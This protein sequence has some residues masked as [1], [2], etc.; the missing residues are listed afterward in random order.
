[1][2]TAKIINYIR[3]LMDRAE[4]IKVILEDPKSVDTI[5]EIMHKVRNM[6]ELEELAPEIEKISNNI[7]NI[8]EYDIRYNLQRIVN[9][10]DLR[11]DSVGTIGNQL[12]LL[13]EWSQLYPKCSYNCC[14]HI[15]TRPKTCDV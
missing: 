11:R 9:E 7:I 8:L 2:M 3:R 5:V 1:M 12:Q 15:Q 13:E 6:R 10:F 4:S 14:F